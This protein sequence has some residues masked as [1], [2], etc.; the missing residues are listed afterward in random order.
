MQTQVPGPYKI[1]SPTLQLRRKQ[2]PQS[3]A[4]GVGEKPLT[5]LLSLLMRKI[6]S[7]HGAMGFEL[8]TPGPVGAGPAH[9]LWKSA[10]LADSGWSCL[11]VA[12]SR[13]WG[14]I[15]LPGGLRP[16]SPGA[17]ARKVVFWSCWWGDKG[18][19]GKGVSVLGMDGPIRLIPAPCI[20]NRVTP[21]CPSLRAQLDAHRLLEKWG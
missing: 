21:L 5:P 17:L 18:R 3:P 9:L 1:A 16:S 19:G 6:I 2:L 4:L 14:R 12:A 7:A 11:T 20:S 10:P 13:I 8:W 15:L